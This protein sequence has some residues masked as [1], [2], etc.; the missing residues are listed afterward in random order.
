MVIGRAKLAYAKPSFTQVKF[1]TD[2]APVLATP[3]T[4]FQIYNLVL[5][6]SEHLKV[7]L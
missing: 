7:I 1:F 3:P 4:R 6:F 2:F 5:I